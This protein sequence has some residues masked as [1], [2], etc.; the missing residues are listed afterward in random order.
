MLML[1]SQTMMLTRAWRHILANPPVIQIFNGADN[2]KRQLEDE[3]KN[4]SQ[5]YQK[6]DS[7][8]P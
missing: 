3:F 6:I 8:K 4:D 1:T 2:Q 7:W 5:S